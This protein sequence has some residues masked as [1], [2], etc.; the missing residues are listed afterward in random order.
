MKLNLGCGN[1]FRYDKEWVNLDITPPCN[2]MA[3]ATAPHLPFRDES[4]ESVW[5]A[6]ILEHIQ[7]LVALQRELARIVRRGGVLNVIVPYYLSPDAWGDPDHCRAFSKQSFMEC[8]WPGFH[9]GKLD[10]MKGVKRGTGED[11][12]WLNC[13]LH[14]SELEFWQLEMQYGPRSF[15]KI[16]A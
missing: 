12:A 2:I 14:R 6:H 16:T 10:I 1:D 15:Q 4:F 7:D 3:D 8:F 9:P 13:Q 5:A 11:I